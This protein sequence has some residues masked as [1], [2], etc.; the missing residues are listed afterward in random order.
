MNYCIFSLPFQKLSNDIKKELIYKYAW[1]YINRVKTSIKQSAF[2]SFYNYQPSRDN[3]NKDMIKTLKNFS[4]DSSII[5][6]LKP[7][8]GNGAVILN[9]EDFVSNNR[10]LV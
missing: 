1:D 4:T 2:K 5:I 6:I 10:G 8:K 3:I 9:K 7:D